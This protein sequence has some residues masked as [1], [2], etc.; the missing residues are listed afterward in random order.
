MLIKEDRLSFVGMKIWESL[1]DQSEEQ[2][3][4]KA[5][6]EQIPDTVYC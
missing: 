6:M 1:A 2:T 3:E 4:L 5:E